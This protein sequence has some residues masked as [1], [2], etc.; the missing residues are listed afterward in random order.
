MEADLAKCNQQK[1][2]LEAALALPEN[3]SNK[4]KFASIEKQYT[5][6]QKELQQ[7]NTLY[8]ELFE[9]MMTW[10]EG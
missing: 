2:E 5:D 4:E 10:E 6:N 1:T 7:L 9:Q 3:F 8:E